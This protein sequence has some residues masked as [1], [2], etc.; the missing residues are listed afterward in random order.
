MTEETPSLHVLDVDPI[1]IHHETAKS[2]S[3]K[4][5]LLTEE[6]REGVEIQHSTYAGQSMAVF[7]RQDK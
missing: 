6:G 1:A 3:I 7:T 5:T 4:P 2:L